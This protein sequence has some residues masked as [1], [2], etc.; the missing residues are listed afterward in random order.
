[1]YC[2]DLR[3][4]NESQLQAVKS[5]IARLVN[6]ESGCCLGLIQ[7]PPGTGNK[8]FCTLGIYTHEG[9]V[10]SCFISNFRGISLWFWMLLMHVM[11]NNDISSLRSNRSN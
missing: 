7:G 9:I 4:L 1:M 11:S 2:H 6:K 5:F 3:R 10:S 8:L